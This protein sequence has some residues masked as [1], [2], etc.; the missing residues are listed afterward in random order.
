[1]FIK[2]VAENNDTVI[3]YMCKEFHVINDLKVNMLI[4]IDILKTEDINFK[5]SIDEMIFINY[6]GVTASMQV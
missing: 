6:K 4:N 3:V 2:A 1:M 5:F